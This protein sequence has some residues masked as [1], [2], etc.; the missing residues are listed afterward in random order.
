[1]SKTDELISKLEGL[2]EQYKAYY[3]SQQSPAVKIM[4][5]WM[6]YNNQLESE[7]FELKEQVNKDLIKERIK[8]HISDAEPV[9]SK[10]IRDDKLKDQIMENKI[11]NIIQ[12]EY[13]KQ[14]KDTNYNFISR[15]AKAIYEAQELKNIPMRSLPLDE[16]KKAMEYY[17]KET[18]NNIIEWIKIRQ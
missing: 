6:E 10:W 7:I 17:Q 11:R 8:S 14:P 9:V 4:P 13:D 3:D 1:M 16:L 18:N 12:A 5:N 2:L 15:F